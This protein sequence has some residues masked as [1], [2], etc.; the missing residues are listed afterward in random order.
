MYINLWCNALI[1]I[2]AEQ[3]HILK[4]VDPLNAH[5]Y[6]NFYKGTPK[7]VLAIQMYY[8]EIQLNSFCAGMVKPRSCAISLGQAGISGLILVH[9]IALY[10]GKKGNNSLGWNIGSWIKDINDFIVVVFW[11]EPALSTLGSSRP[12]WPQV[13]SPES[14]K[15]T[16][17]F[18]GLL[19]TLIFH[20]AK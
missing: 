3:I 1:L 11:L 8:S 19:L 10:V 13:K 18:W 4:N 5:N 12:D 14:P 2:P 20:I 16:N 7:Y 6:T 17:D 15:D 9:L